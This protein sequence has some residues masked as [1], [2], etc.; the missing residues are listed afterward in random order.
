MNIVI[1]G[2]GAIGSLF[3]AYLSKNNNVLLIGRKSHVCA[4]KKKGL[5]ID[6]KKKIKVKINAEESV[7]NLTFKP[8]LFVLT[9]KSYDTESAIKQAKKIIN[10]NTTVLS[11]QNGLDN[12]DRIKKYIKAEKIIAGV[13]THGAFFSEP[14][15]IRHTGIGITVVGELNN[16]KTNRI[17]VIKNNFNKCG[18]ETTISKN[19]FEELWYKAIINSSINPLTTIFRCKNGYLLKNPILKKLTGKICEE[20]TRIGNSEG[21]DVSY[22]NVLEKTFDVIKKTS[23][24]YSSM[25]QSIKKGSKTEIGSINGKLVE[26]GKKNNVETFL[27]EV[28]I[29]SVS[30]IK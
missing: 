12:I 21:F 19:I 27:N 17:N 13:T 4:I 20:S 5:K 9:V 28:L 26:Y 3:G 29:Y 8:D 24:N 16:K 7:D 15:L 30:L 10:E 22:K 2:A 18:I 23:D 1:F 11:L 14:G 25:L 6:G